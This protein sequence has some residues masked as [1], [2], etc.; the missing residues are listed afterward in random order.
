MS[1]NMKKIFLALL[2]FVVF[3]V[4]L[5]A[6]NVT[7][8]FAMN[9]EKEDYANNYFQWTVAGKPA[10]K[11]GFDATAG[12]S[13][14]GSTGGFD[15]VR[16]DNAETTK[17]ASMPTALRGLML[18]P[19]SDYG[20]KEFDNLTVTENGG[21]I[22]VRYIHRG[23]AYEL[24]TD[25]KGNFD[26]LT[27]AKIAKGVGDNN[28]NV[29]TVNDAFLKAGGDKAKM[30]DVDWSKVTLTPDTFDAAASMHYEGT[31]K[32]SFKKGVLSISGTLKPAK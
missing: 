15:A 11:D 20:T 28:R 4:P 13:K 21:V 26:V 16:Y 30:S 25:K 31:L 18:Y 8:K 2:T 27:G 7:I 32:F 10:V 17:K 19:V 5:F 3:A 12:A 29:F 23:T 24:T 9:V 14:A 6:Q 1:K 22:V